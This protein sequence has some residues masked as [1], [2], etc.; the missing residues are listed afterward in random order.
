[1]KEM[2]E[3]YTE[4]QKKIFIQALH[5]KIVLQDSTFVH[6]TNVH[7]P[8]NANVCI[9]DCVESLQLKDR[10]QY[11]QVKDNAVV[12]PASNIHAFCQLPSAP[13]FS[14]LLAPA[15]KS[16]FIQPPPYHDSPQE[17]L[18]RRMYGNALDGV[19]YG[20]HRNPVSVF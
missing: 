15:E 1:V 6:H 19:C 5:Q 13:F 8:K 2:I 3:S 14:D 17:L 10:M 16:C 18:W 4:E 9:T 20:C 11:T 7:W 12:K